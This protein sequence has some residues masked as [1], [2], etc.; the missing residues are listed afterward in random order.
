MKKILK[1]RVNWEVFGIDFEDGSEYC[2]GGGGATLEGA[3]AYARE[4]GPGGYVVQHNR[5]GSKEVVWRNDE[6]VQS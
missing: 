1:N 6:E 3:I 5:D 4:Q 2:A